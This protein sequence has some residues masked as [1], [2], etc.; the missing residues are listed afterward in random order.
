MTEDCDRTPA[1][2][3]PLAMF[4]ADEMQ[5]RGWRTEDV[6]LRMKNKRGFAIDL[7]CLDMLMA[8]QSDNLLL[9]GET[10]YGLARAFDVVSDYFVRLDKA[11]RENPARRATWACPE[12]LFGP[13]SRRALI[14]TVP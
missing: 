2:V 7:L 12:E 8:V 9:D 6:A 4:L 5:K 11:W 10:V 3:F 13:I 1:E 14:R